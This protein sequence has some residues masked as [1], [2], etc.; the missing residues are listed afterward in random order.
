MVPVGIDERG[1]DDSLKV[2]SMAV[3]A[4]LTVDYLT[5]RWLGVKKRNQE[6]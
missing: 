2:G 1:T 5:A 4:D 3:R 6:E